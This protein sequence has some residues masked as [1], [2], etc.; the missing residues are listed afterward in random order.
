M[1]RSKF[2]KLTVIAL[3]FLMT[4]APIAASTSLTMARFTTL[5][6]PAGTVTITLVDALKEETGVAPNTYEDWNVIRFTCEDNVSSYTK[7]YYL[8]YY[9]GSAWGGG[10]AGNV[11]LFSFSASMDDIYINSIKGLVSGSGG[12]VIAYNRHYYDQN[13]TIR[14]E[15]RC[16]D[17]Y[18]SWYT[19]YSNTISIVHNVVKNTEH[20]Y[21]YVRATP[22]NAIYTPSGGWAYALKEP[23][24]FD[25]YYGNQRL[26]D[27]WSIK[28]L[29]YDAMSY[30]TQAKWSGSAWT[31]YP[32]GSLGNDSYNMIVEILNATDSYQVANITTVALGSPTKTVEINGTEDGFVPGYYVG[33]VNIT[34]TGTGG[35]VVRVGQTVF[36]VRLYPEPEAQKTDVDFVGWAYTPKWGGVEAP[37]FDVAVKL[38]NKTSGAALASKTVELWYG[39]IVMEGTTNS[40]GWIKKNFACYYLDVASVTVTAKF[41]GDA[42]Y[43]ALNEENTYSFTDN[44]LQVYYTFVVT[45]ITGRTATTTT[46]STRVTVKLA[47]GTAVINYHVAITVISQAQYSGNLNSEGY[48][49]GSV[50]IYTDSGEYL[51]VNIY[52][53]PL[54][55]AYGIYRSKDETQTKYF[56]DPRIPVQII[57]V[58]E[59]TVNLGSWIH[60]AVKI[61]NT[62]TGLNFSTQVGGVK[63]NT[64]VYAYNMVWNDSEKTWDYEW[65][66]VSTGTKSA[67][68]TFNGTKDYKPATLTVN[69]VVSSKAKVSIIYVGNESVTQGEFPYVQVKLQ[70]DGVNTTS[71]IGAVT[72]KIG[73]GG[74]PVSMTWN[75]TEKTYCYNSYQALNIGTVYVYFAF[76]GDENYKAAALTKGIRVTAEGVAETVTVYVR[77]LNGSTPVPSLDV[78]LIDAATEGEEYSDTQQTNSTG[79]AE[80]TLVPTNKGQLIAGAVSNSTTKLVTFSPYE[81][82]VVT[83]QFGGAA[84]LDISAIAPLIAAAMAVGLIGAVIGMVGKFG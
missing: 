64:G 37:S 11:Y 81:G 61:N 12:Y 23:S 76:A 41:Y 60:F 74:T 4:L 19:K 7:N 63:V 6:E 26:T 13:F 2:G 5:S 38:V 69:Y 57:Y 55:N 16:K 80:F 3:L 75:D 24:A 48:L 18:G 58:G 52:G 82:R 67:T 71:N 29:Y 84:V 49:D 40:T 46:Y 42:D 59:T 65:K 32:L 14:V 66:P 10:Y 34:Y 8:Q 53:D 36:C 78:D 73:Y 22:I 1:D 21:G 79:Y 25:V 72:V 9:T 17:E 35:A 30:K 54:S 20:F 31:A 28:P 68:F 27:S 47:N 83:L 15:L 45:A 62:V 50:T 43:N 51:G 39:A 70:I 33:L 56:E 77:V 44:R